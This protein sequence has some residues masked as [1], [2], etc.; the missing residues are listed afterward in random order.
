[1]LNVQV[2]DTRD[3]KDLSHVFH[4]YGL[5]RTVSAKVDQWYVN[6]HEPL[7]GILG[8]DAK[9]HHRLQQGEACCSENTVSLQLVV[10]SPLLSRF[11]NPGTR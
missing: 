6:N 1:M 9:Y 3:E 8:V 5:V 10:V 7:D 2:E 11:L 4:A